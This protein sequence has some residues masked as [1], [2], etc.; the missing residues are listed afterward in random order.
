VKQVPFEERAPE[1]GYRSPEYRAVVPMGTLPAI[2]EGDW[3]LSESEAIN[4]Y[5]EERF[6]EPAMLPDDLKERA[7]VRFLARFHDLHLEPVARRLFPQVR[8]AHR[9]QTLIAEQRAHIE[10]RL[11]QLNRLVSPAPW[12]AGH[13]IT[14]ADCGFLVTVPLIRRVLGVLGHKLAVPAAIDAWLAQAASNEALERA[15]APWRAATDTWLAGS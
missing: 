11:V 12:L 7:S 10:A 9:D 1:H 3:V 15:L 14:L 6:P 2:Q 8:A 5:L 4:E 13:R